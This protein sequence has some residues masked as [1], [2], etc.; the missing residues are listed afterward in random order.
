MRRRGW[1]KQ[2][3]LFDSLVIDQDEKAPTTREK[4]YDSLSNTA[5]IIAG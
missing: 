4:R 1:G 5:V 3:D 2:Q